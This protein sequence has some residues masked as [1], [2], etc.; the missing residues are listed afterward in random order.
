M[1]PRP[2]LIETTLLVIITI[3]V[4]IMIMT[5]IVLMIMITDILTT[6]RARMTIGMTITD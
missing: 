6:V 3:T 2:G 5:I 4:M 1:V